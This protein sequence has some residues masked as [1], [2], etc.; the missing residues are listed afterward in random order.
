MAVIMACPIILFIIGKI[1]VK[2]IFGRLILILPV[3][4]GVIGV[5]LIIDFSYNQMILSLLLFFKCVFSVVITLLFITTTGMNN[6]TRTLRRLKVP[7]ILVI[8]I[9]MLYRYI[10]L[11]M[12]EAYKIKCAY[13]L[14]TL[15]KKSM[16]I[17]NFGQIMAHMLLRS[18][19]RAEDI[20][21]A[22]KLRGFEGEYY[23][24]TEEKLKVADY[25]YLGIFIGIFSCTIHF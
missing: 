23:T 19:A 4:I 18:I 1:P 25:M 9:S 24:N 17:K 22:M 20:Y 7:K 14:R 13:E 3:I 16:D 10:V 11:M 12:E 21:K 15:D 6:I 2:L 8:Q 5:N